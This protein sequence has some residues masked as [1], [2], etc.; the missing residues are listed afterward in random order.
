MHGVQPQRNGNE[1][2]LNL[3]PLHILIGTEVRVCVVINK[4]AQNRKSAHT[5]SGHITSWVNM[6]ENYPTLMMI[7]DR[8]MSVYRFDTIFKVIITDRTE[9][10][11]GSLPPNVGHTL[12]SDGSLIDNLAVAGVYSESPCIELS[13]PMG[14]FSSIFLTE[15]MAIIQSCGAISIKTEDTFNIGSDSHA[16]L[17]ALSSAKVDS[18]G[19]KQFVCPC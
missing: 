13:I 17:K 10:A 4:L 2:L 19:S 15:L 6:V 8:I 12:Y 7:T 5:N 18:A 9:W 3:T 16:V 11:N 1:V 14:S